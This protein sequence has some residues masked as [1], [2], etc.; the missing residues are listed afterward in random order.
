[1]SDEEPDARKIPAHLVPQLW[2]AKLTEYALD[3]NSTKGKHKA[4]AAYCEDPWRPGPRG[5]GAFLWVPRCD[6]RKPR[7]PILKDLRD[8]TC[9][10]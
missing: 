10:P 9:E 6:V 2:P 7:E 3:G 1:M 5:Q 4:R 8:P